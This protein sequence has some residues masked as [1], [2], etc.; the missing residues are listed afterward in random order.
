MGAG[1]AATRD[2]ISF[3]RH[4]KAD[5]EGTPNMLAGQ[6]DHA[7]AFG[8]SQS[9][10]SLHDFLHLGVNVDEAGRAVFEGL[11]PHIAGG[12]KT[13]TDSRFSQPARSPYQ[14]ADTVY[15]GSEFPFTYPGIRHTLTGRTD[16]L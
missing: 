5:A 15:P 12:K 7:I 13:F 8:A 9:G 1:F 11:M 4:E 2:I 6:I 3:L 10:R 14:H 16:G